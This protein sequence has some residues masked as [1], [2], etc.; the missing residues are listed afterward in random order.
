[1]ESLHVASPQKVR[2][3]HYAESL[4][5]ESTVQESNSREEGEDKHATESSA[6][7]SSNAHS[8]RT[9]HPLGTD[10]GLQVA[11]VGAVQ[12]D[13]RA[14]AGQAGARSGQRLGIHVE[15]EQSHLGRGRFQQRLGMSAHPHRPVDHPALVA[16]SQQKRDL[17]DEDGNVNRYTP[18]R[19]NRSKSDGNP[20][21]FVRS[22]SSKRVRSQTSK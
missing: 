8:F 15:P 16:R 5:L 4:L 12:A 21:P 9:L 13:P 18:S 7:G 2:P 6:S 1:M 22:Y 11:K 17:V 19:D 20:S 14:E 3:T 10:G